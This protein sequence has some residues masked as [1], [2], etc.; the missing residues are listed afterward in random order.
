MNSTTAIEKVEFPVI[1]LS[2]GPNVCNKNCILLVYSFENMIKFGLVVYN[3]RIFVSEKQSNSWIKE[4]EIAMSRFLVIS[5]PLP[6]ACR[7][8]KF[9]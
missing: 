9:T 7:I 3:C 6:E 4:K 2:D 5:I 8:I 1:G